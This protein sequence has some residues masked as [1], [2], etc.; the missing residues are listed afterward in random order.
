MR[1]S[2]EFSIEVNKNILTN[3]VFKMLQNIC[4]IC[5]VDVNVSEVTKL[6]EK[7]ARK[8]LR[9]INLLTGVFVSCQKN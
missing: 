4:R 1:T 9:Q 5:A 8:L 3:S 6:F 2:V 7:S